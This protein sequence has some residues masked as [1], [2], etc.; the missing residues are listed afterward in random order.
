MRGRCGDG[1][2]TLCMKWEMCLQAE[3]SVSGGEATG[4]TP[5]KNLPPPGAHVSRGSTWGPEME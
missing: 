4:A 5:P 3:G 1:K 2:G